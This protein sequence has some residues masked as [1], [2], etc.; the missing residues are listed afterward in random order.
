MYVYI[1]ILTSKYLVNFWRE[2]IRDNL[3]CAGVKRNMP[4]MVSN[5]HICISGYNIYSLSSGLGE[6]L[7]FRWG[8]GVCNSVDARKGRGV[9]LR[10]CTWV[11]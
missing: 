2:L 9:I 1:Y 7:L 8:G 10:L 6:P 5:E 3:H 11:F 4:R